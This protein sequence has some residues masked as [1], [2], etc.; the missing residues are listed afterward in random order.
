MGAYPALARNI[1]D[2]T[3]GPDQDGA[4][5]ASRYVVVDEGVPDALSR[6]FASVLIAR[7]LGFRSVLVPEA[8]CLVPRTPSLIDEYKRK[9][10]TITRGLQTV[11]YYRS[12][13]NPI[14]FGVFAWML[15]SHKLVRW[16]IPPAWLGAWVGVILLAVLFL[17]PI[18]AGSVLL[19][20]LLFF[21]IV[22]WWPV[23]GTNPPWLIRMMAFGGMSI[24][25]GCHAW[26]NTIRGEADPVWEPTRR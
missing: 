9:V 4:L 13:M 1:G 26:I 7:E 19:A 23:K 21:T 12:M 18:I 16:L 8:V 11:L 22:W 6:D 25:A 24:L 2:A 15:A 17:P 5:F 20:T 3:H 14:R 10:R